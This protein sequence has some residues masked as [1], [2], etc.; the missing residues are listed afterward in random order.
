[1]VKIVTG[2][3][4]AILGIFFIM[5]F[6]LAGLDSID[7]S[8]A[9]DNYLGKFVEPTS[10]SD[11]RLFPTKMLEDEVAS[12]DMKQLELNRKFATA[13]NEQERNKWQDRLSGLH[14][15][16]EEM[17]KELKRRSSPRFIAL[18]KWRYILLGVFLVIAALFI[19]SGVRGIRARVE[20]KSLDMEE[21]LPPPPGKLPIEEFQ[22][23]INK[24]LK[25]DPGD[26]NRIVERITARAVRWRASDIH[27]GREGKAV[28]VNFRIDGK[29]YKVI[30]LPIE[31]EMAV[32]NVI[33]V[34]ANMKIYERRIPQDGQVLFRAEGVA[35][36]L[37]V[38]VTPSHDSEKVVLRVFDTSGL[39]YDLIQLG[40]SDD[41]LSNLKEMLNRRHGTILLC[42]PAGS[43]KTTTIYSA[44]NYIREQ[45]KGTVNIVT[46]E[47]PVE[48]E[49]D[50]VTQIQI[51]RDKGLTYDKVLGSI[52]RQ[53]P[54]VI[55]VGEIRDPETAKLAI[56]AGQTGHL[57]ISTVHSPSPPGVFE[58]LLELG[59][60]PFVLYSSVQGVL[61]QRLVQRSCMSCI[62]PSRPSEPLRNWMAE[63]LAKNGQSLPDKTEWMAGH[64]CQ[65]CGM[66]GYQ[67]RLVLDE[68]LKM[69]DQVRSRLNASKGDRAME[70]SIL[71]DAVLRPMIADGAE[72]ALRGLTTLEELKRVLG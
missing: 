71:K 58:R 41:T 47:D 64:G 6:S 32:I 28:A 50:G 62:G 22:S 68:L 45:T 38:S 67:G 34:M 42:G 43:G 39:R 19:I 63:E 1:M 7:I 9:I 65:A 24:L 56:Q 69:T 5:P 12:Y 66:A 57:L 48:H 53:D 25:N 46:V 14:K 37:R 52:L 72:K 11:K 33:K 13:P 40:L 36:D 55:V 35:T 44:L 27:I 17:K 31:Q 3:V 23:E 8:A 51:D 16:H 21:G 49:I 15:A 2:S 54:E 61:S 30:E 70:F 26:T 60:E 29:L 20:P 18:A 4:I 10:Y 59:V